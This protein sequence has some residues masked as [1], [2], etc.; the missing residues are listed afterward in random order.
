MYTP[1]LII[2]KL[3]LGAVLMTVAILI[4]LLIRENMD[5]KDPEQAL[6]TIT[7]T[8]NGDMNLNDRMV[9]RAGYEWNFLTTVAKNTPTYTSE[10]LRQ[11][12]YPV[13]VRSLPPAHRG[14]IF[15]RWK[16]GSAGEARF[17]TFSWYGYNSPHNTRQKGAFPENRGALPFCRSQ[18]A[19]LSQPSVTG[20]S[21]PASAMAAL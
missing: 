14:C 18:T 1:R 2:R 7:V 12:I 4:T 10:G 21:A 6:P 11:Q 20:R 15:I 19:S 13:T 9:F 16:R 5:V 3:I 8:V 17:D